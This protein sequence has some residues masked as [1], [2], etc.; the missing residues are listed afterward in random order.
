MSL[1]IDDL[2]ATPDHYLH[3][4]ERDSAIFMPMNRYTY[5][6]SLFLDRRIITATAQT[7]TLPV[8]TL[9]QCIP[10]P[11]PTA[12]IF[13][14][15][16]CGSTLLARALDQPNASLVLREPLALRQT[17]LGNS[18]VWLPLVRAMI[19]KRYRD[20]APTLIKANV[21]VNFLLPKL[22]ATQAGARAI[23]L[24]LP[25]RSYLMAILRDA[26][27]RQWIRN[28]TSQLASYIGDLSLASDADRAAALW[29]AQ[30]NAFAQALALMPHARTL[31]AEFFFANPVPTLKA[32]AHHLELPIEGPQ[33]EAT[34]A[35]PLFATYSKNPS[36][37]FDNA[38]RLARI[39]KVE[40]DLAAEI[41]SATA[42]LTRHIVS[43]SPDAALLPAALIR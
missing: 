31:N 9:S 11:L 26:P 32:A 8:A 3:S 35:G 10:P 7:M 23:F 40:K 6:Q 12:W 1:T 15:A 14:I 30:I 17:A 37:V 41:A 4:F 39:A 42:W 22:A 19:S 2:F 34:V 36:V 24:Y 18:D 5:Y 38:A 33:L 20:D 21:P 25:F 29:L 43:G 27:H 28:V 13:H 16:H